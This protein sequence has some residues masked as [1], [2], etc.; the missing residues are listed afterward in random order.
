MSEQSYLH[1]VRMGLTGPD[2]CLPVCYP[3]AFDRLGKHEIKTE[4][5]MAYIG[6]CT[7]D[8][9]ST[10]KRNKNR[11]MAVAMNMIAVDVGLDSWKDLGFANESRESSFCRMLRHMVKKGFGVVLDMDATEEDDLEQTAVYSPDGEPHGIGLIPLNERGD[12][13]HLTSSWLP[14]HMQGPQTSE[15]VFDH[16]VHQKCSSWQGFPFH[17]SNVTYFPLNAL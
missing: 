2:A 14:K 4:T 10:S 16:L 5:Y 9:S 13:F 8:E 3:T 12:M 1:K 17:D 15:D 11:V 6:A 7:V